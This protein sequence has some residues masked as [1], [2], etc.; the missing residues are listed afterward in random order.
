MARLL[1][2]V[3]K[4]EVRISGKL[5]AR[6]WLY[7]LWLLVLAGLVSLGLWQLDRADLKKR[8]LAQ[9]QDLELISPSEV[10]ITQA[11][12]GRRWIRVV[13][14]VSWPPAEP[15]YL[16]NRTYQGQAGYE[17][18]LPIRLEDGS[19]IAANLG[20]LPIPGSRDVKPRLVRPKVGDVSAVLGSPVDTFTLA[21][22]GADKKWR[23][24]QQSLRK[25][26]ARWRLE[27]QPWMIWLTEPIVADVVAR[28]PGAG[29]MPPE[30]H[31]GYAV[32]WFSLAF[33]LLILGGVLEWKIR[34]RQH[35]A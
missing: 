14:P 19:H 15:L 6:F 2:S 21:E 32:Q 12:K 24:Q 5:S 4:E 27:L 1:F 20:W 11:M 10:E 23:L 28:S 22:S 26:E 7:P 29:Q 8:W 17:L 3:S 16:D 9:Q 18:L 25:M 34:R 35:H 30:R 13:L 33:A 31:I